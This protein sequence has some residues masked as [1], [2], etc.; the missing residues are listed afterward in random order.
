MKF[1]EIFARLCT[2]KGET[3]NSVCE[4]LGLSNS[5]YSFWKKNDSKPRETTLIKIAEYFNVSVSYLTESGDEEEYANRVMALVVEWLENND[6]EYSEE[7]GTVTIGKDG[8]YIHLN[9]GDFT[10]ECL[11]IKRISE[12]GFELAMEDWERRS[13]EQRFDNNYKSNNVTDSENVINNSPNA[14]LIANDDDSELTK[15]EEELI[16]LYRNFS[17]EQQVKLLTYAF[18]LREE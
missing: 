16:D 18:K 11:A 3:P 2:E 1:Y 15:Q 7:N 6:Y 10:K 9:M 13:F 4:K 12:D 8:D 17:L 5:T 14:T